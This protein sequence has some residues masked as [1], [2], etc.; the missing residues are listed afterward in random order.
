MGYTTF[1]FG[2]GRIPACG[3]DWAIRSNSSAPSGLPVFPLLSLARAKWLSPF[4]LRCTIRF[5]ARERQNHIFFAV[6]IP[7]LNPAGFGLSVSRNLAANR[8]QLT[9]QTLF[10]KFVYLK[11]ILPAQL[12]KGP[13]GDSSLPM[14]V[15]LAFFA[16]SSN[17]SSCIP[18]SLCVREAL[19]RGRIAQCLL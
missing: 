6:R 11:H 7:V 1:P 2:N 13:L 19:C 18:S 14:A 5:C 3:G 9:R 15:P 12:F 16:I 17:L 8:G 4:G 10:S